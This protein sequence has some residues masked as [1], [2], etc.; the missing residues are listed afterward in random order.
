VH[1]LPGLGFPAGFR[2]DLKAPVSPR[3]CCMPCF[4]GMYRSRGHASENSS[5]QSL[6]KSSV[7]LAM[8]AYVLSRLDS[9]L[10]R[11]CLAW[12]LRQRRPCGSSSRKHLAHGSTSVWLVW[13]VTATRSKP[14]AAWEVLGAVSRD[15]PS[16]CRFVL[17]AGIGSC[18][19]SMVRLDES[20]FTTTLGLASCSIE[21]PG[22]RDSIMPV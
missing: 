4:V 15:A 14:V 5:D 11:S 12:L 8:V 1:K 10:G 19:S 18:S 13:A 3:A 6:L 21:A 2:T 17:H 20:C 7:S 16:R 22:T 9:P